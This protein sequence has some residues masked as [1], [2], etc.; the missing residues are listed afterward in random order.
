MTFY[1]T[2]AALVYRGGSVTRILLSQAITASHRIPGD[3]FDT[4]K[5]TGFFRAG[6]V[7]ENTGV[8]EKSLTAG[9]RLAKTIKLR[10]E[11][12]TKLRSGTVWPLFDR[13]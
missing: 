11:L 1:A 8:I 2:S 13:N 12:E 3:S 5:A 7:S 9:K 4:V 10:K 6:E